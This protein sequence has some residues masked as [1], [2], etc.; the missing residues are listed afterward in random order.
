MDQISVSIQDLSDLPT[1]EESMSRVAT[2]KKAA[3]RILKP[4]TTPD[5]I[6]CLFENFDQNGDRN[7]AK[8]LLRPS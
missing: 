2:L 3:L 4:A 1:A 7:E 5:G 6:F 8:S